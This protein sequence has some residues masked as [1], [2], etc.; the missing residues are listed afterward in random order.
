[1]RDM[2]TLELADFVNFLALVRLERVVQK[3]IR[4]SIQWWTWLAD[5][6]SMF[7]KAN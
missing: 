7:R 1:M 6:I 2:L 3:G 4:E 5:Y